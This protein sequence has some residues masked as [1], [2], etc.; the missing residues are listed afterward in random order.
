MPVISFTENEVL[1]AMPVDLAGN[2]GSARAWQMFTSMGAA[3]DA[4]V[5]LNAVLVRLLGGGMPYTNVRDLSCALRSAAIGC[6]RGQFDGE[7]FGLCD[8]EPGHRFTEFAGNL[9]EGVNRV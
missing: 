9:L 4:A 7:D 1:D 5:Y 6:V 2:A 8:S 3:D